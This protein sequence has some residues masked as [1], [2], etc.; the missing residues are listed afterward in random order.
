MIEAA[1]VEVVAVNDGSAVGNIGVVVVDHPMVMPVPSPVVPS[2][3][4]SSKE[5]DPESRAEVKPWAIEKDSGHWI[6]TWVGDDGIAVHKP[7]IIG[8]NVDHIRIS[9]FDDDRVA[10]SRDL[11]LV[12]AA[13]MASFPGL[14]AHFLNG[15][16][17]V[18][19]LVGVC[20]AK[21]RSP[22]KILVHVL[23]D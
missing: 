10:L 23:K 15:I 3:T 19:L 21:R 17:Y 5:S 13:Q 18:L 9:R 8:G 16:H 2:P 6:P 11:L 1:V 4:K 7:R 12:T 14:L 22:G 20:V